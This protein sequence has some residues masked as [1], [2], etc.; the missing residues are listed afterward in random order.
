MTAQEEMTP[1][2]HRSAMIG[3]IEPLVP[4]MAGAVHYGPSIFC[5][6]D[7][8]VDGEPL[9]DAGRKFAG[10][11][12]DMAVTAHRAAD[13]ASSYLKPSEPI[14]ALGD[15]VERRMAVCVLFARALMEP[16]LPTYIGADRAL[17]RIHK[18]AKKAYKALTGQAP[19]VLR[20]EAGQ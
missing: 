19:V 2:E 4:L 9:T 6:N 17:R 12:Y 10:V 3:S 18:E 11:V 14:Q 13:D 1:E 7:P 16:D 5:S 15:E 20:E 8:E